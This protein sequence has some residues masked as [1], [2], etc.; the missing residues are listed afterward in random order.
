MMPIGTKVLFS[1]F[2]H[3]RLIAGMVVPEGVEVTDE[4]MKNELERN[5]VSLVAEWDQIY[6][7]ERTENGHE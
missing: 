4:A 7:Y 2:P 6:E 3:F 1:V 5:N